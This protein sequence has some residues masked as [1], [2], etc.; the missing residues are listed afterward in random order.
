VRR[1]GSGGW[2]RRARCPRNRRAD[3]DGPV[4]PAHALGA[5]VCA[6]CLA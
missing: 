1:A 2:S 4:A 5:G 3:I 6:D